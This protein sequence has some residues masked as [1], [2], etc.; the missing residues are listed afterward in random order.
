MD[1][2]GSNTKKYTNAYYKKTAERR[3]LLDETTRE[4]TKEE[5]KK[6]RPKARCVLCTSILKE[7]EQNKC[8]WCL[9]SKSTTYLSLDSVLR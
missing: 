2:M 7:G 8:S 9:T 6:L 3:R 5:L 1:Y 4:K